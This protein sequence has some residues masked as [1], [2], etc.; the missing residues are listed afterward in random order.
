MNRRTTL[1]L[2]AVMA[3]VWA[4]EAKPKRTPDVPYVPT[5]EAAVAEMLKL[6]GVK[7]GMWSTTSAVGTDAS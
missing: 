6:A 2:F 3:P 1:L 5:T 4:Q 7:K